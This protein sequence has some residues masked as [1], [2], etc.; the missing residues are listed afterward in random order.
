MT[1][2]LATVTAG[3]SEAGPSG[4]QVV[5]GQA[6][7]SAS[8]LNTVIQQNSAKAI[9]NWQQFSLGRNETLN[10]KQP[11]A[12]SIALNRVTGASSSSIA[13]TLS[14]SGQVWIINPN[15]VLFG[16]G[17]QVN[18]AGLL[19]TTTDISD[20]NFLSGNYQFDRASPN[21]AA[22]IS[23]WGRIQAADGGYAVLAGRTV[24]NAGTI[25][26]NLG[27]VVLGGAKTF[28]VDFFGDK[29]LSFAVTGA[30][31]QPLVDNSGTLSADGGLVQMSAR[32]AG[33]VIDNVINT[34]GIIQANSVSVANGKVILDAGE[35]GSISVGP[36]AVIDVSGAKGG[37][38]V[39]IGDWGHASV[40]LA[41]GSRIDAS[42]TGQGQ[43]GSVSV[44]AARTSASGSIVARGGASGGD[45]G[46][47]ETS[48]HNL[49][50]NGIHVDT[51]APLGCTGTWLL[52]PYDV[53]ISASPA[54]TNITP[55]GGT[56]TSSSTG[57]TILNTDL[58]TALTSSNVTIA[59]G[60][61]GSG[62]GDIIVNAPIVW[63]AGKIL[64]LDASLGRSVFLNSGITAS[65][66]SAGLTAIAGSGGLVNVNSTILMSGASS[67]SLI[68]NGGGA[69]AAGVQYGAGG[70]VSVTGTG[71]TVSISGTSNYAQGFGGFSLPS[72]STLMINA[73]PYTVISSLSSVVNPATNWALGGP[74][75]AGTITPIGSSTTKFTG[76]FDGLGN[77][78]SGGIATGTTGV[79][80][81]GVIGPPGSVSN[82][83]L[84][85]FS[86][87][88]TS[89]VGALA[90]VNYGTVTNVYGNGSVTGQFGVG[91]LIGQN[92]SIVAGFGTL[93]N[94]FFSGTVTG[95]GP[96]SSTRASAIGGLVGLNQGTLSKS[97]AS[98][99]VTGDIYS[100]WL[101][102]LVGANTIG[103]TIA[104]SSATGSVTGATGG[105]TTI[106]G[107]V[108]YSTT[109]ITESY[110]AGNVTGQRDVGGLV[111]G[112][113]GLVASSYATGTVSA[114]LQNIGGL[115][116]G[117]YNGGTIQNSYASGKVTGAST[118]TGALVGVTQ[119]T[120]SG[121]VTSTYWDLDA[122]GQTSACGGSSNCGGGA[123][124]LYSASGSSPSAYS[125]ASYSAW[126]STPFS[127]TPAS[128]VWYMVDGFT[129]PMLTSEWSAIIANAHQLEMINLSLS[130][131]Y[132]LANTVTMSELSNPSGIWKPTTGFAPIGNSSS[133]FTGNFDG[134]GNTVNGMTISQ[135]ANSYIGLFGYNGGI[136]KNL[137]LTSLS[138][139]GSTYVGGLAGYSTGSISSV[140]V[141][142]SVVGG[143]GGIVGGLVGQNYGGSIT[144][145]WTAG[146]VTAGGG[147]VGGL[148]GVNVY[149]GSINASSSS[150]TVV[151][152]GDGTGGLVGLN[153][154]SLTVSV[155]HS[156]GTSITNSYATGPV[157]GTSS[158]G[159]LVGESAAGGAISSSYATGVVTGGSYV[160]GLV[161]Y[162]NGV[163]IGP[164]TDSYATGPV[165]GSSD[166]GGLVGR[167][168][169]GTVT[170]SYATGAVS[171]S[172][173]VG[174]LLGINESGGTVTSSF[175]NGVG[176]SIGSGTG[177]VTSQ[178]TAPTTLPTGLS[179]SVWGIVAGLNSGYP[180]LLW[181]SGCTPIGGNSYTTTTIGGAS[182]NLIQSVS[183]LTGLT[184]YTNW[185]STNWALGGAITLTSTFTPFGYS[186]SS[187]T[188]FN[189]IFDGQN[190]SISGLTI[191]KPTDNYIG[192]FA[193]NSGTIRNVTLTGATV[194]GNSITGALA[195]YNT[196]TISSASM[197]GTV[198]GGNAGGTI[199]GLV[200]W[201]S[202]GKV[203]SSGA[204]A[205]VSGG[206]GGNIGGLI[207]QNDS[208]GTISA[209]MANATVSGGNGGTAVGG[210]AGYNAGTVT[211]SF[212]NA[213][214][215]GSQY[216]GGLVGYNHGGLVTTS[217]AG[218][219]VAASAAQSFVGGLVGNNDSGGVIS[220]SNASSAVSG[221][222]YIGGLAGGNAASTS[223]I[224]TSYA[225]GPVTG[226]S[227]VGGLVGS[228]SGSVSA[229]YAT[230]PLSAGSTVGGLVGDNTSGTVTSSFWDKDTSGQANG[231]NGSVN[232]GAGATGIYSVS[233]ST[234]S[235][236]ASGTYSGWNFA[237][238][239]TGTTPVSGDWFMVN[240]YTRPILVSEWSPKIATLRQLELINLAMGASYSLVGSVSAGNE[241]GN[242]AG[243]WV[244]SSGFVPI[245]F[246][247]SNANSTPTAFTG[248]L[249]GGGY[250][251]SGLAITSP[252]N[253]NLG[254]FASIGSA[255]SVSNLILGGGAVTGGSL[256]DFGMLAG[257]NAGT[258][259]KVFASGTVSA[260]SGASTIGGLIGL[261]SGKVSAGAATGAVIGGS[262][263]HDIGG[264]VGYMS[265][266]TLVASFATGAVN[267]GSGSMEVGGLVGTLAG[268]SAQASYAAG[269]VSAGTA[270][271]GL[272]G[273]NSGTIMNGYSRGVV[274]G[275]TSVGGLVGAMLAGTATYSFWDSVASGQAT[276]PA[277][278][279]GPSIGFMA[280]VQSG[281]LMSDG[282]WQQVSGSPYPVLSSYPFAF[283][284]I[285]AASKN[286]GDANPS[287][288]AAITSS[289]DGKVSAGSSTG[290]LV[291]TSPADSNSTAGS[292]YIYAAGN[293]ANGYQIAFTPGALT[294][295]T[296]GGSSGGG[297]ATPPDATTPVQTP[298]VS[299]A[300]IVTPPVSIAPI[301]TPPVSIAPIVTP[302]V[303]IAPIVTPPVS[304][305]PIVTPPPTV[306]PI[307]TIPPVLVT[308]PAGV[309]I[310]QINNL[311]NGLNSLAGGGATIPGGG[312]TAATSALANIDTSIATAVM[313]QI[314]VSASN[315]SSLA[316][317]SSAFQEIKNSIEQAVKTV[318]NT[319]VAATSASTSATSSTSSATSPVTAA[320]AGL[321]G[322][323][324]GGATPTAVAAPAALPTALSALTSVAPST[325]TSSVVSTPIVATTV[326]TPSGASAPVAVPSVAA[327]AA[328]AFATG[329]TTISVGGTT[330]NLSSS[331]P[332]AASA[333]KTVE[334]TDTGGSVFSS[335]SSNTSASAP[336]PAPAAAST[337]S[338]PS[339][340]STETASSA[341][342]SSTSTEPTA[343]T[344]SGS[345]STTA[346][347]TPATA[348]A[349]PASGA[350]GAPRPAGTTGASGPATPSAPPPDAGDRAM[351]VVAAPPPVKPAPQA[352]PLPP[353]IKSP[354]VPGLVD[355][356]R[357]PPVRKQGVPGVAGN[358]SSSGNPGRW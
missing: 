306:T 267:G 259:T 341:S 203:L 149:G 294:V 215:I 251:I 120:T 69:G 274:S 352:V 11:D 236:Y 126:T 2:C 101:G 223:T 102:G 80:M 144:G 250:T 265:G 293:V 63:S 141:N 288:T 99:S 310:D 132:K 112:N 287:F 98:A 292:Y 78:I 105:A 19:A 344:P 224:T 241:L 314:T 222:Q 111:G 153:Y 327:A 136:I 106:G 57:T 354:V 325:A 318:V 21:A 146:T 331:T 47:I 189:A 10:F 295:G 6:N 184:G 329:Q 154:T 333:P 115:A 130:A 282:N 142:G 58:Q 93:T 253:N 347:S 72:S 207:G 116:G 200:G 65:G 187:P 171:G 304:V 270:V 45:G 129:R 3:P 9:I 195:G 275:A 113:T 321:A 4:A 26:A 1:T 70:S 226:A 312:T 298:P 22:A 235:A 346:P 355:Q 246:S 230:G 257:K 255:G 137:S 8:A 94:S 343:T 150:A 40:S 283:V 291:V 243:S 96:N 332:A 300:P 301:V 84:S 281:G 122:S 268:G 340:P 166:V 239:G 56:Y 160:G 182:F 168:Y 64:A 77:T 147:D 127:T 212:A 339:A 133:P 356:V 247:T 334:A 38:S 263:S 177:T 87:S 161:G 139:N 261:N 276:S 308:P 305:A 303:S 68:L 345:S 209:S 48:G 13:G 302:P 114:T 75:T 210:L 49:S 240:G 34:S 54:A 143:S 66:S 20:Q 32:T 289:S 193:S 59:V 185:A 110:A 24:N 231:C 159:G 254:L 7:V 279:P 237:S 31:D 273:S 16:P 170:N 165:S 297:N 135:P 202:G 252:S 107:L 337:P 12:N 79:G 97:S 217:G 134:G 162:V 173:A 218:G 175:W 358:F 103:G 213:T 50:V 156:L 131:S 269:N 145:S 125:Q 178:A 89:G 242:P 44:V 221:S 219:V 76:K 138:V 353:K 60:A 14:A 201:N 46:Q 39:A 183:D 324:G 262:A 55:S 151:G 317:V 258:V 15:G 196:G 336:A 220:Y 73:A 296:S 117:N 357:T 199:G 330:V 157:S 248:S 104:D 328:T 228:N 338:A 349:Q 82:L 198:A 316:S 204:S 260:G 152:G 83:N 315:L 197:T 191:S 225:M 256:A 326:T 181:Q 121:V 192:L 158:V 37:G 322:L 167:N 52:D 286:V 23:N 234:P 51:A 155:A 90:G 190:Y 277:G 272:V 124:G 229:S 335:I 74:I 206:S 176:A 128:G 311:L 285:T 194:G 108:G 244:S 216:V 172:S 208:G 284:S 109:V 278:N 100:D 29:L 123:I 280:T 227:S 320:L 290:G 186:A 214:A 33:A 61:G 299:I 25:T 92:S 88:G 41:A 91:G 351:A 86:V 205:T 313:T 249:A 30:A 95:V 342:S 62:N 309:S 18:V 27:S 140:S 35:G 350:G 17:A 348:A 71:P 264:L 53:T 319:P 67:Q 232:C 81:F 307:V 28:A 238:T 179:S 211:A 148:V 85:G 118:N 119:A 323:A 266:G 245:G 36:Q 5:A 271:G 180:C 233:A 188:P 43:G 42:A 174:G 163:D 164:V 169:A